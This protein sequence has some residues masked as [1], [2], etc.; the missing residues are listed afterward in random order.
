MIEPSEEQLAALLPGVWSIGATNFPMW[1]R[2]DRLAPT[3]DYRLLRASPLRLGDTV[4]YFTREGAEKSIR[5]VD[6]FSRGEFTW[7]GRGLL[8]LFRSRWRVVGVDDRG[9]FAVIRF[10]K[11]LA[12][13]AGTDV[14]VPQG[15]GAEELRRWVGEEVESVGLAREEFASLSWLDLGAGLA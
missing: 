3:F 14:I 1:L 5:G 4:S 9:R 6:R 10:S 15:S 8:G 13:P 11:T 7:R 2:G 12:T